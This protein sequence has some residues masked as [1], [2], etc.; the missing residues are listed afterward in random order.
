MR[1][2]AL[3][4]AGLVQASLAYDEVHSDEYLKLSAEEKSEKIF[5]NCLENTSP[6][7]WFS[8]F[9][10]LGLFWESM[11]PTLTTRGDEMPGSRNKY[12]H[13]VGA[14]AQVQWQDLGSHSYTGL[15]KGAGH[16]IVRLSLAKEPDTDYLTTVPGMGLK[17]LRDGMDSANLVAMYSLAGQESWNFFRNDFSNH[18]GS[19]SASNLPIAIK[20]ARYVMHIQQV[21]LSDWSTHDQT[22]TPV[23]APVFPYRL[24]FHPTGDIEFSDTYTR[25]HTEDLVTIQKG[26]T[27]YEIYALDKPVE[28][29]GKENHIAN[30]VTVSKMVTSRWGD[31]HLFFRHQDM[32]ED[33]KIRPEWKEFTP[34]FGFNHETNC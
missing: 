11:C 4:L 17:F 6:A 32:L 16:G 19:A 13:T 25:P 18:I 26:S 29:G 8:T 7:N 22:G 9:K 27:L 3:V 1:L 2:L 10:M 24:R 5:R 23:V 12:I 34:K 30:L 21:G 15:F 31:K 14:V 28:M 20:F 33:L